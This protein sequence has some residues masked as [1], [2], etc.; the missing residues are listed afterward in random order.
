MAS[1]M[2]TVTATGAIKAGRGFCKSAVL[3]AGADAASVVL[4]NSA[5]GSG[6]VFLKLIAA[7]GA[8]AVW[9]ANDRE[10]VYVDGGIY[11]TVTGTTPSIS[12][13]YE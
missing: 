9:T 12:V 2:K 1:R 3:A 6:T 11:A 7:A 13:E 5:A 10:G 8:S 4:D